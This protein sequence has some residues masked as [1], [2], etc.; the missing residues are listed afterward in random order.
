V[1]ECNNIFEGLLV[2]IF[3]QNKNHILKQVRLFYQDIQGGAEITAKLI[4]M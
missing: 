2:R 4:S 3:G 1:A